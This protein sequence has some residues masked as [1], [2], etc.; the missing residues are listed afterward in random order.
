MIMKKILRIYL[1]PVLMVLTVS[2]CKKTFLADSVNHNVPTS[3]PASL[4]LNGVLYNM[5]DFPDNSLTIWDQYYIYNYNYYGNNQYEFGSG[6]DYYTTL[7]NV[8]LM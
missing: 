8:L 6:D 5:V 1:L 2:S 4:L 7:K 3:V